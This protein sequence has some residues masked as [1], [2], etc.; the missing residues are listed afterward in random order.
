MI[1]AAL[2]AGL[3]AIGVVQV[4]A[5]W[6]ALLSWP[7]M[8]RPC[9]QPA[10]TVKISVLKPLHGDEPL[11]EE[12][13]SSVCRQDYP[14]W[15][16]VFGVQDAADGALIVVQRLQARFPMSRHRSGRRSDAARVEPQ[17][18]QSDQHA[19][20]G[21]A[22]GAGD[23]QFG[24]A[25]GAGLPAAAGGGAAGAGDRVGD[26]A[27]FGATPP[28][29]P[30]RKAERERWSSDAFSPCPLGKGPGGGVH[31]ASAPQHPRHDPDQPLLSARCPAGACNGTAGLPRG[32]HGARARDA[33]A[34]RRIAG[35]G[36]SSGRRQ[37]A[38]AAG[39][40]AWAEGEAGRYRAG[41]HGAGNKLRGFVAARAALGTDDQG[42]GAGAVRCLRPAISVGLGGARARPRLGRILVAGLV[43]RRLGRASARRTWRRT[44]A[45]TFHSAPRSGFCRCG[46]LC[47]LP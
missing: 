19:A 26:N 32:D 43:C 20:G 16:V 7:G 38:R 41:D 10:R 28:P 35:S 12:A 42:A 47:R 45:R 11:L 34:N 22:R 31:R 36:K 39:P 2:A 4:V 13:L 8:T 40:G 33:G 44:R 46:S 37:C 17:G 9:A 25:R 1:L 21:E 15:Q 29:G 5:G 3:S 23:C 18:R 27:V 14:V 24:P 6:V 30:L